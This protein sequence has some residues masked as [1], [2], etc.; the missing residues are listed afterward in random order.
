MKGR[1]YIVGNTFTAADV[2]LGGVLYLA[3][4][5]GQLGDEL[6]TRKAYSARLMARPAAKKCYGG[7]PL[8]HRMV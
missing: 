7:Y 6:P 1:E 3:H 5:V 4:R 8:E 2:V